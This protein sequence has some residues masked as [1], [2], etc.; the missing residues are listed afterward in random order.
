VWSVPFKRSKSAFNSGGSSVEA[1]A[2]DAAPIA[3]PAVEEPAFIEVWRPAGRA[4]LEGRFGFQPAGA[5]WIA[6]LKARFGLKLA[7]E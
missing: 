7:G 6:D 1:V 5:D 3:A 2:A 4:E